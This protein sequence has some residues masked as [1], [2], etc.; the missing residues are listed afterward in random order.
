[1]AKTRKQRNKTRRFRQQLSKRRRKE[2]FHRRT[3]ATSRSLGIRDI[4]FFLYGKQVQLFSDH[5]A[6]EL[7][8]KRNELNKQYSARLTRW[9][10]RLNHFDIS[11]KHTAG[12][13]NPIHGFF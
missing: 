1:M 4:L 2:V 6:L 5:Q 3:R 11:L 7:L 13:R 8:L 12:K 9:F 10:D